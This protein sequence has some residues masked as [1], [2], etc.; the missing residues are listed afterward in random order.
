MPVAGSSNDRNFSMEAGRIKEAGT[1]KMARADRR[2]PGV[3][4]GHRQP[5]AS[6]YQV[7]RQL[8]LPSPPPIPIP[9]ADD[10][11]L[12]QDL[13]GQQPQLGPTDSDSA[14]D[15]DRDRDS[16]PGPGPRR[17]PGY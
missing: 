8:S 16:R 5:R 11:V 3:S 2:P 4:P 1:R 7:R 6:D 10:A 17:N 14:R 9:G 15:S 12:L 13:R